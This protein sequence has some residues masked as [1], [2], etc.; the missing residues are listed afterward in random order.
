LKHVTTAFVHHPRQKIHL[1]TSEGAHIVFL[2]RC[3]GW[4]TPFT[5][6]GLLVMNASLSRAALWWEQ[7]RIEL[8]ANPTDTHV[9]GTFH[10]KNTGRTTVTITDV[11]PSCGCTTAELSR[12][13]FEP[14]EQGDIRATFNFEGATGPQQKTIAVTTSDAPQRPETL[15]LRVTIPELI[16]YSSRLVLWQL[17]SEPAERQVIVT[18]AKEIASIDPDAAANPGLN[19]R[20]ETLERGKKYRLRLRPKSAAQLANLRVPFEAT[21]AD[22]TKAQ[23]LV[24]ALIR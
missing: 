10:F 11:H 17:G 20:V 7:Q 23:L 24:Y 18:S 19:I 15:T 3:R 13:R 8:T 2:M 16:H 22:H 12:R 14:G 21:F 4:S 6:A 5:V 9:V 1:G